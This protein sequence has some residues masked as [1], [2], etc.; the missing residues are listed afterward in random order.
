MHCYLYLHTTTQS[1]MLT[2]VLT[3]N[4]QPALAEYELVDPAGRLVQAGVLP[5]MA[6]CRLQIGSLQTGY[7]VARISRSG[8]VVYQVKILI[9]P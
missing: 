9:Q 4:P 2:D 5:A 7:Y 6:S 8:Q 3:A 1:A